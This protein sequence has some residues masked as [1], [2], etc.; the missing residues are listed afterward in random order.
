[1]RLS[2]GLTFDDLRRDMLAIMARV[3]PEVSQEPY[4]VRHRDLPGLPEPIETGAYAS[5]QPCPA[6]VASLRA[7]G[8]WRGPAPIVVFVSALDGRLE[9]YARFIHE[10][11]H[12]LPFRPVLEAGTRAVDLDQARVQYAAWATAPD[13]H[14]ADLPRWAPHHGRDYLRVVCHVWFRALRLC[15][16]DVPTRFV[17]HHEYDLSPLGSYVDA[18]TPELRTTDTST[19]FAE[20]AALP[21]PEAFRELFDDDK[22]RWARQETRDE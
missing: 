20:I 7:A 6:T 3:A 10:L 11:A 1:M 13:Y 14:V 4:L 21:M 18:L 19:P 9:A 2:A 5:A 16:L 17:L 15:S 22:A 8:I 12:L